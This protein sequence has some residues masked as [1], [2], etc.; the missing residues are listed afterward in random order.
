MSMSTIEATPI[1]GTL[2]ITEDHPDN[3]RKAI[4][5]PVELRL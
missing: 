1:A 5:P 3:G 4:K 2:K